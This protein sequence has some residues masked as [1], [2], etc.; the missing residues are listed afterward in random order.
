MA[1]SLRPENQT[2]DAQEILNGRSLLWQL[3]Q[4]LDKMFY[5]QMV[6]GGSLTTSDLTDL[7]IMYGYKPEDIDRAQEL[8]ILINDMREQVLATEINGKPNKLAEFLAKVG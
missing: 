3:R 5:H 2:L 8:Y 4:M 7:A 6:V 1:K